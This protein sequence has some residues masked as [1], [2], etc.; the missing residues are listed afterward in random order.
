LSFGRSG[1]SEISL[2]LEL[3]SFSSETQFREEAEHDVLLGIL[4]LLVRCVLHAGD[5]GCVLLLEPSDSSSVL[6][7]ELSHLGRALLLEVLCELCDCSCVLL[8]EL[9][10]PRHASTSDVRSAFISLPCAVRAS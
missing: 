6:V 1:S 9:S 10:S 2:E 8:L 5:V 3:W 4:H 7:L